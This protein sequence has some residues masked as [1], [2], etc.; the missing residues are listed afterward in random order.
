MTAQELYDRLYDWAS[1]VVAVPVCRAYDDSSSPTKGEYVAIDDGG[2][3]T[4]VGEASTGDVGTDGKRLLKHDYTVTVQLW[5]VRGRG[6]SL[7]ALKQS[8]D[9]RDVRGALTA[10]GI[11]VLNVGNV[12]KQPQLLDSSKWLREHRLE[13]TLT[14]SNL[15]EESVGF[16]ESI[17][18]VPT[19]T[20][21]T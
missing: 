17:E 4:P 18:F 12:E 14:V 6:D 3:W 11:G 10:A 9:L 19:I 20:G 21:P 7:R 5:E 16:F 1:G 8:L 15:S 2:T 13:I